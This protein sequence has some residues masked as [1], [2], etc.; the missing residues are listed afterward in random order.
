MKDTVVVA[1]LVV[2]FAF[3]V[4]AHAAI[5]FGLVRRR[6]WWRA[7]VA[8]AVPPL[9]PYWAWREQM[10]SRAAIWAASLAIYVTALVFAFV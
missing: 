9:A 5:V 10:R 4:T 7:L 6:P 2:A 1:S 3:I 8:L